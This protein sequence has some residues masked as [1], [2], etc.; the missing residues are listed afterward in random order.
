ML[1]K[2]HRAEHNVP[3]RVVGQELVVKGRAKP[4]K[5]RFLLLLVWAVQLGPDRRSPASHDVVHGLSLFAKLLE[6]LFSI[7]KL[8]ASEQVFKGGGAVAEGREID[9][10]IDIDIDVDREM[11]SEKEASA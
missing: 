1:T 8:V 10:D 11:E 2:S 7:F 6:L 4:V 5:E 9:I 3:H